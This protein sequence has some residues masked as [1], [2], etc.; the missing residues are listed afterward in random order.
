MTPERLAEIRAADALYPAVLSDT[1]SRSTARQ[2]RELLAEVQRLTDELDARESSSD[3]AATREI[4][5]RVERDDLKTKLASA[6]STVTALTQTI[7]AYPDVAANVAAN[8]AHARAQ[9]DAL[10]TKA[11]IFQQQRDGAYSS[12]RLIAES[13]ARLAAFQLADNTD[14]RAWAIVNASARQLLGAAG[15]DWRRHFVAADADAFAA[16]GV[17]PKAGL[18]F[19]AAY[20]EDDTHIDCAECRAYIAGLKAGR[21]T[22]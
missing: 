20:R 7:H 11:Q 13:L 6:L 14:D 8:L 21:N 19:R 5:L 16:C 12:I 1:P 4:D 22:R 9:R 3:Q 15:P 2:R 10:A 17:E 18:P